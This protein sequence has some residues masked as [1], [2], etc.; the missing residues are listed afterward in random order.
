MKTEIF[1]Q[2]NSFYENVKVAKVKVKFRYIHNILLII[3][4]C[5]FPY[6]IEIPLPN[7]SDRYKLLERDLKESNISVTEEQLL[8]LVKSTEG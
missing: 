8:E 2:Y 4:D 5:R 3:C 7:E 6:R 1:L